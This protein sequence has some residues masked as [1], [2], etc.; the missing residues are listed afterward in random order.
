MKVEEEK[1][2]MP[3]IFC[4]RIHPDL[5]DLAETKAAANGLPLSEFIARI[6]ADHLDRPDLAIVPRKPYRRKPSTN[7]HIKKRARA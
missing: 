5:H 3:Y 4:L 2:V 7:G 6:L 1:C